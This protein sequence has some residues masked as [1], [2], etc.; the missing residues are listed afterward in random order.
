MQEMN[1]NIKELFSNT[2]LFAMANMGSKFLVFIMLPF[3]T[4]VLSPEEYGTA[5]IIQTTAYLL[6]P[7]LTA[8]IQDAVL[9][10]CFIN[11]YKREKILSIGVFVTLVGVILTVI[12]TFFF[13]FIPI[14]QKI[15]YT[16]IFVPIVVCSHSFYLLF[17]FFSRGI[18]KVRNS[19]ISGII[20]TFIILVLNILF[21]LIFKWGIVGYLTSYVIADVISAIYLFKSCTIHKYFSS[22][23]K[24]ITKQMLRFSIPLIPTSLSWWMLS[25]FNNYY[26]LSIL[27]SFSVG[28]YMASLRL[29]SILTTLSD[30]FA[31]AWLLTALKNYG[32]EDNRRFICSMHRKFFSILCFLTGGIILVSP[33]LAKLLLAKDFYSGW[34]LVPLLFVSVFMGALTGF[35]GSIFSAEKKTSIHFVSTIIGAIISILIVLCLLKSCGLMIVPI[36]TAIGNF[37]IWLIR[38]EILKKYINIAMSTKYAIMQM[39]LLVILALFIT[40]EMYIWGVGSFLFLICVNIVELKKIATFMIKQSH[41]VITRKLQKKHL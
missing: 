5:G 13:Y 1:R 16:L 18:D 4:F 39:L 2:L 41:G 21:L 29:P 10:F 11:E 19:A 36:A 40:Y 12:V 38:K 3:Y 9:R 24:D 31:Q 14:F 27:G 25:N 28:L 8:K 30:I 7:L 17:S 23:D 33:L 6:M 22:F 37:V 26:I 34:H 32:S 20:N 15:G 35:Y